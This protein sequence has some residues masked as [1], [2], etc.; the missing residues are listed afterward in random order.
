M[1]RLE[2]ARGPSEAVFDHGA[3]NEEA[4]TKPFKRLNGQHL[5]S[6]SCTAGGQGGKERD[7]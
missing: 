6:I 2:L 3:E 7:S 4:D 1:V 5:A